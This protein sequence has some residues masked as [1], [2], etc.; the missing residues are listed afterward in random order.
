MSILG[1]AAT[2]NGGRA[3]VGKGGLDDDSSDAICS[4]LLVTA[5]FRCVV[6][7]L[8]QAATQVRHG[9]LEPPILVVATWPL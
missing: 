7:L 1:P 3:V 5:M 4:G 9:R 6:L 8:D 2:E